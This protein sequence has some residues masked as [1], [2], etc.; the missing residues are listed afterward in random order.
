MLARLTD[1]SEDERFD[2]REVGPGSHF[3]YLGTTL[4]RREGVAAAR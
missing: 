3:V 2:E 1:K 4:P